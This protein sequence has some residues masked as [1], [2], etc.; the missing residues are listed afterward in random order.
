MALKLLQLTRLQN[1]MTAWKNEVELKKQQAIDEANRLQTEAATAAETKATT[2]T[3][4][5]KATVQTLSG[6]ITTLVQSINTTLG[7][8]STLATESNASTTSAAAD[9]KLS[10]LITKNTSMTT[11]LNDLVTKK[12]LLEVA[13]DGAKKSAGSYSS[14]TTLLG[15]ATTLY[16]TAITSFNSV[17]S[18]KST[19]EN[20]IITATKKVQELKIAEVQAAATAEL[21]AEKALKDAALASQSLILT[22]QSSTLDSKVTANS[23]ITAGTATKITYDVK[24]LVTSGTTLVASDIPSLDASKIT[25]GTI[26]AARLPSYV[27]DVIEGANLAAFPITGEASKI[28]VALDTNKTYRWSGSAYVYITSGAVD[29]VAG[30]TGVVTLV[31]GDV[32]LGNIDNTSDANKPVSTAQ[33]TAIGLKQDTLVSGTNIKTINSTTLLGSGNIVIPAGATGPQGPQGIQGIQGATGATGLTG[34]TGAAGTNGA[35]GPQGPTGAT[36]PTGPAGTTVWSGITDK[37][38]TLS[39]Y[40]ITDAALIANP[41]FTGLITGGTTSLAMDTS[42]NN[43]GSFVCRASGTGD[44]NLAGMSFHNDAYAIKLGIRADGYFG[45]GGWS[46]ATWSWYS[47]PSGNMVSAGNVTAYSD[48]R[49]KENFTNIKDA[50]SKVK[51]LNGGT[52]NWKTGIAHTELKA[53]SK[54]YGILANEVEAIMPEIVTQS[55]ELD[56]ESYRTVDY[57]KI[58]PLLIEAIKEQQEQLDKLQLLVEGM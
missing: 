21:V 16:N 2:D 49:L 46:R 34:P 58:V 6:N 10:N 52:F 38:T 51:L 25:T 55:I 20:I 29:S 15:T 4:A 7:E 43:K 35:T 39:G 37:P 56:G 18:V 36:G 14:L 26:D 45:L 40:G 41:T 8:I 47:D 1:A 24:G 11:Y 13:Y 23:N 22:S 42:G 32:G 27:D 31:K 5:Y 44:G 33:A 28:Y 19:V 54:D 48:P 9:T 12:G 57:S 53:G 17:A 3:T 30:K 50:V